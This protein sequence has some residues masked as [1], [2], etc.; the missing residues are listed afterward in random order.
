GARKGA[1]IKLRDHAWVA[2]RFRE[3]L[4]RYLPSPLVLPKPIEVSGFPLHHGWHAQGDGLFYYGVSVES[5][6]IKD[7][8]A[9][10]LRTSLRTLVQ[11][12]R[13]RVRFTPMQDVLLCDLPSHA[14]PDV[15][16]T[17]TEHGVR[18]PHQLSETRKHGLACPAIP[19]C[20]LA[21]S[22]AERVLPGI[23]DQLEAE[24]TR[25]GLEREKIGIRITGCP[26]GC[27]RPYQ[28]DIGIV[29]RSGDK[30][31]VFVGGNVLGT[32]LNFLLKDLV[33]SGEI[34]PL[35]KPLLA[36][37]KA[38]RRADEGFGDYCRRIGEDTARRV[39]NL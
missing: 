28:S 29:G 33:P 37:F 21:I 6:R 12:Y 23:V 35:L 22:E 2:D 39:V 13:P 38:D 30:Y 17:L 34:V 8:G 31:T 3:V 26:N 4:Q 20:G 10:R 7:E 32:R 11:R 27:V 25:L 1:R 19:T 36:R 9:L 5:G 18:L 14:S 15:H 24:L 16:R